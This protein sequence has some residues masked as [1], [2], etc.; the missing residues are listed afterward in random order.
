MI[1]PRLKLVLSL[2][3]SVTS[4]LMFANLKQLA[5]FVRFLVD[6]KPRTCFLKMV[7]II[8]GKAETIEQALLDT[9]PTNKIFSF[10]S[11]GAPVMVGKRTGV[12]TRMKCHNSEMVSIHCGAH[13]VALASS[14][15]E[16]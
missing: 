5:I 16:V 6:G 12:A 10:G 13:R 2:A 8:N 11:D 4:Q 7:D 14:Y 15:E 9:I 3:Y 1:S